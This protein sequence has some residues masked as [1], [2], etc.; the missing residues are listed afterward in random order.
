[1]ICP[2]HARAYPAERVNRFLKTM[3][4]IFTGSDHKNWDTY[5]NEFQYA[6]NTVANESTK[7]SSAF[8]NLSRSPHPIV[9]CRQALE[10]QPPIESLTNESWAERLE[11]LPALCGKKT[12]RRQAKYFNKNRIQKKYETAE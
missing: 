8:L 1:M 9:T 11:K 5:L 3:T 6:M 10:N 12:L 7:F 2:H 4:S